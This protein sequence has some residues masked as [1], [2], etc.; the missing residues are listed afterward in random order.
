MGFLYTTFI[1]CTLMIHNLPSPPARTSMIQARGHF[2]VAKG[3]LRRHTTSPTQRLRDRTGHLDSFCR[4]VIYSVDQ[5]C[6]KCRT[7]AWHRHQCHNKDIE[8][9]GVSV[10]VKASIRASTRKC[11]SVRISIPSSGCGKGVR[12]LE[13]KL[14]SICFKTVVSFSK[15]SRTPPTIL[16]K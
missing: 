11:R 2:V 8:V 13:F 6:Q 5:C 16:R 10:F 7:R 14:A 1:V 15:V 9:V 3:S 4:L 12:G